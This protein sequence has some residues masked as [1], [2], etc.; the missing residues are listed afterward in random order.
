MAALLSAMA[1]CPTASAATPEPVFAHGEAPLAGLGGPLDLIEHTGRRFSL[2]QLHGAPTLL[3]FGFTQCGD[4]CPVAM[5]QAVQV[6]ASF[7]AARPPNIVFVTLDPLSDPPQTLAAYLAKFDT[8][9]IGLTGS[10]ADVEAAARRYGVGMRKTAG[11]LEHSSRW[12]L[13]DDSAQLVRVYRPDTPVAA[14]ARDVGDLARARTDRL[15]A[16]TMTAPA[17]PASHKPASHKQKGAP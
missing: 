8:R 1:L 14:L 9:I 11:P 17:R 7:R 13:L 3:F 12:Y 4:T 15:A 2:R 16:V 10:P 6:L 5:A